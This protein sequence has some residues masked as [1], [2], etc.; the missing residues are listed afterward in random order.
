M[1]LLI[2]LRDAAEALWRCGEFFTGVCIAVAVCW[3]RW[4]LPRVR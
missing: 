2:A 1:S 4:R 3:L